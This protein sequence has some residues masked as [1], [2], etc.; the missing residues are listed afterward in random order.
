MECHKLETFH[1][2]YKAYNVYTTNDAK[3]NRI[4]AA[5]YMDNMDNMETYMD[6]HLI[7]M[8]QYSI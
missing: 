5:P 6:N 2:H 7:T 1:M 8:I 4:M 3:C